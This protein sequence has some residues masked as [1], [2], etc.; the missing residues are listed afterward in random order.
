[1]K[2]TLKY[3]LILLLINSCSKEEDTTVEDGLNAQ[4][5]ALNTQIATLQSQIS[6]LQGQNSSVSSE[7]STA[8]AALSEAQSTVT[9]SADEIA[10]LTTRL[11][12][13]SQ[14]LNA[15][16]F[17]TVNKIDATGT[18]SDQTAAQAKQTI[19][20]RWNVSGA[21]AKSYAC[22]FKFIEFTETN[23][24]MSIKTAGGYDG[25]VFGKYVLQEDANGKVTSVDL[26]FDTGATD[27]TVAILTNIVV[28]D[29]GGGSFSATFDVV[30][31]LPSDYAEC[32][33]ALSGTYT[34]PK[35]D[36]VPQTK[37]TTA[38]SNHGKIIGEWTMTSI[39]IVE[40]GETKDI[41]DLLIE[42]CYSYEDEDPNYVCVDENADGVC[43]TQP[44]RELDPNCVPASKIV[45]NFSTFGTY[46]ATFLQPN[47]SPIYVIVDSWQ[48]TNDDLTTIDLN[49]GYDYTIIKLNENT[50]EMSA[51]F[52]DEEGTVSELVKF[53]KN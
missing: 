49:F 3:L 23:Y 5:S 51:T 34:A 22:V 32:D 6:T 15:V 17:T 38:L 36:P 2:K 35:Q 8:Q 10:D 12:I 20:G 53:S 9:T 16:D 26:L 28:T 46:S 21:T 24:L 50:L 33:S 48:W 37:T 31:T 14:E 30:L 18:V 27:V 4:I 42:P 40:Q 44:A 39:S 11:S 1:M 41:N 7:L 13:V 25:T 43:D 47:G 19:Y 52:T 45:V 29:T